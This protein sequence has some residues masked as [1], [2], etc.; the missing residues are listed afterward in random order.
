MPSPSY[1][2]QN[3][4]SYCF[5]LH[6]PVDLQ[7]YIGKKELRYS[8]QTG[9]LSEAKF[10]SR[11]YAAN[12]Q[13]LFRRL[14][15]LRSMKF[16][17][18][19]IKEFSKSY[20]EQQL[21]KLP[22][23]FRP[24]NKEILKRIIGATNISGYV[25]PESVLKSIDSKK[26]QLGFDLVSENHQSVI[27][28]LPELLKKYDIDFNDINQNDPSFKQLCQNL[29]SAKIR[30][31]ETFKAKIE[32]KSPADDFDT[33][34]D[35][36]VE[37]VQS[38]NEPF[39]PKQIVT[40]LRE[41]LDE[42]WKRKEVNWSG[43]AYESYER[44]SKRLLQHF[45][46]DR[47]I[48]TIDYKA[49]EKFRDELK[50]TGNKGK[51]IAIKTVNLHLEFYSG[52]FNHAIQSG[53][54]IHNPVSGVKF[55]DKRKKQ[56]LNDP[57]PKTDLIKLFHSDRYKN[58]TFEKGWMFWLPI[59]LLYTGARVEELCQLYIDDIKSIKDIWVLDIDEK[60]TDQKV[61]DHEK[62]YI[63]L[64]PFITD[65]LKFVEYAHSLRDKSG[66]VFPELKRQGTKSKREGGKDRMRYGHYPST[67]WFPKY[68]RKECGIVAEKYK[69]TIHSFRHN[70]SSCL[71]EHDVQEY[72]IAMFMGH[73][74]DQI[75]TGRYGQKFEPDMLM[76]KAVKK[77]NYGIDLSHLKKSK[78]VP[79]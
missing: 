69:K 48:T 73:E 19:Q 77:L 62:R 70:V 65:E 45:G 50:A 60:R 27:R 42:Y 12:F 46:E 14:R 34:V 67:N 13:L 31:I 56:G 30:A 68:K 16:N 78:F 44:Y 76:E 36:A 25:T 9:Y 6:V 53:R 63:P 43:A 49:M 71:M 7:E 64:H 61:K 4:Y 20:F 8:L 40:P 66:R 47:A 33:N 5:R 10:K 26:L 79:K 59:L 51:P 22:S 29:L 17:D 1:L 41:V 58:D 38:K 15:E 18:D 37:T 2:I 39:K 28:E 54:I 55:S 23:E 35:L 3:R 75:S 74:H 21:K 11:F 52:L 57:F 72:V 32:G 24:G